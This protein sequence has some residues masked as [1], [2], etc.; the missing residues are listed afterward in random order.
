MNYIEWNTALAKRYF[1]DVT[2][3]QTFL[4]ITRD[5]LKDISGL[6]TEQ[7]AL[8]DFIAAV[9]KGPEWTQISGCWTIPSKAH[10][11]LH[12]DP[13]YRNRR[14]RS[15][16]EKKDLSGHI[17]WKRFG[18]WNKISPPYL[19]YL[20]LFVLAWTEREDTAPGEQDLHGSNY[21]E[22][23]N[24]L[25]N[26][27]GED[28]RISS[29]RE[30]YEFEGKKISLNDLWKDLEEWSVWCRDDGKA[31]VLL[32][33]F[34]RASDRFV[35]LPKYYGLMKAV[36]LEQLNGL[37][38]TMEEAG[39]ISPNSVPPPVAFVKKVL[40]FCS[41]TSFLSKSCLGAL[42]AAVNSEDHSLA[43]AFG[44]L[45]QSKYRL[46][47][48]VAD[49]GLLQNPT[50][51]NSRLAARL[52]RVMERNG[53]L[54]LVCRLRSMSALEKLPLE[55]GGEYT[56]EGE[57]KEVVVNWITGS[58]W[59]SLMEFPGT[60][61]MSGM[62]IRSSALRIK[63]AMIR[64]DLIV[65]HAA[66]PYFLAGC[67]V[68]VNEVERGKKYT[69]LSRGPTR[70]VLDGIQLQ[71]LG[72]ACPQGM[73][74]YSFSVPSDAARDSWP[75]ILPPLFEE[76]A[77]SPKLFLSGFRME[78]RSTRFPIGL[79]IRIRCNLDNV[80]PKAKSNGKCEIK[81][82]DEGLWVLE[83]AEE[84]E[85][86]MSLIDLA[87]SQPPAGWQDITIYIE[88]L[89]QDGARDQAFE[90]LLAS[91]LATD[92]YP[93]AFIVLEEGTRDPRAGEA[94]GYTSTY[95]E[96]GIPRL[97]VVAANIRESI[98]VYVDD[99]L[100]SPSSGEVYTL[101][102]LS[103]G[104]HWIKVMYV[105]L[106]ILSR[107][108]RISSEPEFSVDC[109]SRDRNHPTEISQT[110]VADVRGDAGL[111]FDW[112]VRGDDAR[113]NDGIAT[114]DHAGVY[115]GVILVRDHAGLE[116]GKTYEVR[117]GFCGK[118][119]A[120]RWFRFKPGLQPRVSPSRR[121]ASGGFNSL[122]NAFQGLSFP[123]NS[124]EEGKP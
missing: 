48:G 35:F 16:T 118:F 25:L 84:G 59:F 111:V 90:P 52:L 24:R 101:P 64:K 11:C 104:D 29:F 95:L 55:E 94:E 38:V 115:R 117:F 107:R 82:I 73:A 60:D 102:S 109:L 110:L 5:T 108:V 76:K 14:R 74:C 7:A 71:E 49:E 72:I 30:D 9:K 61:L 10:N 75:Q 6:D 67:K 106:L 116:A 22:P 4:C 97:R 58:E 80:Q 44:R 15:N 46:C 100:I 8:D 43:E 123:E 31:A 92:P 93:T 18:G 86:T 69:L 122:A 32:P 81:E 27:T 37:F 34:S 45:L 21:Y 40:E 96:T 36:D 98:G 33:D 1:D 50:D 2:E 91:D 120:S 78:P 77:P 119:T 66:E 87:S 17:H 57:G 99:K 112:E 124:K 51:R 105:P 79:P 41:I 56:F 88:S 19:A 62:E 68:E 53:N 28:E 89:Y 54:K 26:T 83:T 3:A 70:P 47:D 23:L 114:I 85:I 13:E 42:M 103:V 63:A 12:P 65:M 113:L 20:F 39:K 121:P